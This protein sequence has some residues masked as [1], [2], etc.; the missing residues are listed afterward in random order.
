MDNLEGY[1]DAISGKPKQNRRCGE[2]R[3]WRDYENGYA[4]GSD[5]RAAML[6]NGEA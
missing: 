4:M 5:D 1:A 3:E 2:Y 6:G